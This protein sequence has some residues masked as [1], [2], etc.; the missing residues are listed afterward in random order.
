MFYTETP[1]ISGSVLTFS[2]S[3]Q[4]G[5]VI[6]FTAPMS[7]STGSASYSAANS[8]GVSYPMT[9]GGS[10]TFP[11]YFFYSGQTYVCVFT[12]TYYEVTA[13]QAVNSSGSALNTEPFVVN[14]FLDPSASGLL[15][16]QMAD[17]Q[18]VIQDFQQVDTFTQQVTMTA[19]L[20]VT[21]NVTVDG[22]VSA[23]QI[24]A[25]SLGGVPPSGWAPLNSPALTGTP[26][27]PEPTLSD[28]ANQ[29]ATVSLVQQAINAGASDTTEFNQSFTVAGTVSA[30][31]ASS[32]SELVNYEQ[33]TNSSF[34]AA[35]GVSTATPGSSGDELIVFSQLGFLQGV[36]SLSASANLSSS[37]YGQAIILTGS[38]TGTSYTLPITAPSGAVLYIV[39]QGSGTSV[40]Q[41]NSGQNIY[42]SAA[43]LSGASNITLQQGDSVLIVCDGTNFQIIAGTFLFA[44]NLNPYVSNNL[45]VNALKVT[46]SSTLSGTSSGTVEYVMPQQG[47]Y[48]KFVA[49]LNNYGN[50]TSTAQTINFPVS[51][52]YSPGTTLNTTGMNITV[53]T[54]G[55]TLQ[56]SSNTAYTGVIILEGI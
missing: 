27:A 35:L 25:T 42:A 11:A 53:S 8:N 34:S 22:E 5:D 10:E 3:F 46:S 2:N 36:T 41:A 49:Y 47:T 33:L 40:L 20:A 18:K 17:L 30:S 7:N 39:Q 19:G 38:S 12:G 48:K 29:I 15:S 9:Y 55:L 21:G 23:T 6:Q 1:T 37:D 52:T 13:Q 43:G 24:N 31:A 56:D 14:N 45:S 4:P 44:R 26:T 28:P 54:S 50:T 32:G 16:D 51:F